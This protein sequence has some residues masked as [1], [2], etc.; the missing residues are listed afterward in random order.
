MLIKFIVYILLEE[1]LELLLVGLYLHGHITFLLH[2]HLLLDI[3]SLSYL[4]LWRVNS[5]LINLCADWDRD[6]V[7]NC[8]RRLL[9][10]EVINF[11]VFRVLNLLIIIFENKITK[12]CTKCADRGI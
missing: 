5:I 6:L 11:Y 10:V 2:E 4:K 12:F 9:L 8:T 3:G 1:L 7:F